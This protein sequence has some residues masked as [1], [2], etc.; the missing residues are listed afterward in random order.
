[1]KRPVT[2]VLRRA[3]N[4]TLNNWPLLVLRIAETILFLAIIIGAAIATIV[5]FLVS[6]GMSDFGDMKADEIA[7]TLAAKLLENWIL[8][9][10]AL[11]MMLV[12]FAVLIAI[13]AFID[14]ATAQILV[15]SERLDTNNAFDLG[16]WL[17]GGASSWWRIFWIYN[18]IWS[19]AGLV[20]LVPLMATIAGMLLMPNA[21][22]RVA[23]GCGGLA[24]SLVV[25]FP[26]AI[27][28]AIWT[29]K[30]VAIV[31]ARNTT[32][33]DAVRASRLEIVGDLSRHLVVA[34]LVMA[35]SI[36]GSMLISMAGWPLS[37]IGQNNHSA[38]FGIL[39]PVQFVISFLQSIFSAAVNTWFLAA[40]IS[41]TEEH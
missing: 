14:G 10:Y 31:V 21:G 4:S 9:V 5:P 1:M 32:V 15:D 22:G 3:F 27:V 34:I 38:M 19:I 40:Y 35:I 36:A 25:M 7:Q 20:M 39:A 33:M 17:R 37:L 6:A 8:I 41:M 11:V 2:D 26:A 29:Q 28:A 23:I 18:A 24:I 30:A 16:R 12:V 13:H